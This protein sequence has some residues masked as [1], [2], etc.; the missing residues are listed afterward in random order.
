M[1]KRRFIEVAVDLLRIESQAVLDVSTIGEYIITD[2]G[3]D[4]GFL[5]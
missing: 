3:D 4:W 1:K 2:S 5:H